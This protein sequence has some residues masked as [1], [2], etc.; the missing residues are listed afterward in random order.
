MA[1][2]FARQWIIDAHAENL[3]CLRVSYLIWSLIF[4]SCH[5]IY[6]DLHPH[7]LYSIRIYNVAK[8]QYISILYY[9]HVLTPWSNYCQSKA[10]DPW[11]IANP[12]FPMI[13]FVSPMIFSDAKSPLRTLYSEW[14][15]P[16]NPKCSWPGCKCSKSTKMRLLQ[17]WILQ[18]WVCYDLLGRRRV[19]ALVPY[20][21]REKQTEIMNCMVFRHGPVLGNILFLDNCDP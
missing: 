6:S 3:N 15:M 11:C 18:T 1:K 14:K 4:A 13:S 16:K 9:S 20:C 19:F 8:Y 7:F 2:I 12:E 21:W 10:W 17:L 5:I